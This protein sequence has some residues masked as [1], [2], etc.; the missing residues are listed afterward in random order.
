METKIANPA[1]LGLL[2]FAMTTILLNIH[3]LGV[4]PRNIGS[5]CHGHLLRGLSA[6]CCG[7]FLL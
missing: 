4:L 2:G 6:D 1:P 5:T 3:N 7:P